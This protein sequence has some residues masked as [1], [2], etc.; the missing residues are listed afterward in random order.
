MKTDL[1]ESYLTLL[2]TSSR[3]QH[4]L[5]GGVGQIAQQGERAQVLESLRHDMPE[6]IDAAR[7]IGLIDRASNVEHL[8][9]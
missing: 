1:M 6:F 2:R 9:A 5:G 4:E 8:D 3:I 7:R